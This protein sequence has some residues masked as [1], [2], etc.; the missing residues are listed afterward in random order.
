[1]GNKK[2]PEYKE[3]MEWLGGNFDPEQFNI[4]EIN[5]KLLDLENY[6]KNSMFEIE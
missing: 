1:V 2:H 6:M 4:G 5:K 3:M